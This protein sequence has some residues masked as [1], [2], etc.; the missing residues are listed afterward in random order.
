MPESSSDAVED[1]IVD[2]DVTPLPETPQSPPALGLSETHPEVKG[3]HGDTFRSR[4]IE[5]HWR[6]PSPG[7][8]VPPEVRSPYRRLLLA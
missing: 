1:M 4:T 5:P 3:S 6:A 2:S 7:S 8:S